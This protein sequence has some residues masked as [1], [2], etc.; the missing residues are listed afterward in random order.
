MRGKI[1]KTAIDK[2]RVGQFITDTNPVGFTARRLPSGRI[3]YGYRFRDKTSGKQHW[4]GIGLHGEIT[5]D[6]AR[7]KALKVAGEVRDGGTPVSA[8][9]VAARR[10]QAAGITVDAVLDDF[11]TRYVRK[12]ANGQPKGLRS[13]D[14]IE[15]VFRV[16]VRP[17][18]GGKAIHDLARSDI[19]KLLDEVEDAGAPVMAD[20]TLAHLRK[21][22]NWYA[23]R[24]EKFNTPIVKGMARTKPNERAR[25]RVLDDQEIRD[26][27]AALGDL[28]GEA[29]ACF[30]AFVRTLFLT[31]TRLRMAS[32]MTWDEI[33]DHGWTVPGARNKGGREHLVPLTD[34][35]TGLLGERRKGFVFSSDGGK[36]A[37]KGFSKAKAALDAKLAE[38]RKRDGRKP[39]PHFTFHDLRRTARSLMSRAGVPSDHAER[40]LG[41]VIAGVRGVYD[42]HEFANEKRDALEK[43]AAL[44]ERILRPSESVVSFPKRRKVKARSA[45]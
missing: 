3:T 37:F 16:Y 36:T 27:Y 5:P 11:L 8:A 13:A 7:K 30:P 34:T 45:R 44:V 17:R 38:L 39:M 28:D 6:Q 43:L 42:R 41:H 24:D 15:R 18:L 35:V 21:A 2:L 31:G 29:P 9:A 4:L 23:T 25:K 33:E 14:E 26:L 32:D 1:S 19:V 22:L 20:R 12:G 40:V 10:R